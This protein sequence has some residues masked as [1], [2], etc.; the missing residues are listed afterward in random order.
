MLAYKARVLAK[1][2]ER[3]RLENE[4]ASSNITLKFV[5]LLADGRVRPREV[6]IY[7]S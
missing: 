7:S 2:A 4:P 3:R 1:L 5:E 6:E